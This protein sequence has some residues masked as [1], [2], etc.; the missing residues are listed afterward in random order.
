MLVIDYNIVLQGVT[1]SKS[2]S[3]LHQTSTHS[4]VN[5][6]VLVVPP[7]MYCTQFEKPNAKLGSNPKIKSEV[8][9]GVVLDPE[10]IEPRP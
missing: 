1:H 3:H 4:Y 6:Q 5:S 10:F 2:C 7:K 8:H 9:E